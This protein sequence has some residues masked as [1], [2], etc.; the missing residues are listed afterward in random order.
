M[1][2]AWTAGYDLA[3]I[4]ASLVRSGKKTIKG[5]IFCHGKSDTLGTCQHRL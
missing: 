5:K 4:V 2:A 1:T 3:P